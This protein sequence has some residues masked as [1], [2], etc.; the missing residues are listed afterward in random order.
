MLGRADK[1]WGSMR[2]MVATQL[3]QWA[4]TLVFI[5]PSVAGVT[6]VMAIASGTDP[7][8]YPVH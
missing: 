6:G 2:G 7:V 8:H 1:K 3:Q 4:G 5:K